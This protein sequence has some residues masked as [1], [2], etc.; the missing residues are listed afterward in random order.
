M[1][2]PLELPTRGRDMG[3]RV[4]ERLAADL[5]SG[6]Y[7]PG[8]LL[9]KE[10]ELCA[11]FGMSRPSVRS[12]LQVLVSLGIVRR[13]SGHGTVVEDFRDWNILDPL[14]TRW[15][16]EHTAPNPQFVA[17]VFE[18][19]H[20]TEPYISALAA[21]KAT[22][23]D[24]LAMEEAFHGMERTLR[25]DRI[26]VVDAAG[27][28]FTDHDVEFHAAIYRATRNLVWAQVAHLLR[29]AITLVVR[30]SNETA[31]ELQDSLQRHRHLMEC[32][33]LRR[34]E[35]AFEAARNVM[36]RTAFDLGLEDV[37]AADDPLLGLWK[38]ALFSAGPSPAGL[39]AGF[40]NDSENDS[41]K[42]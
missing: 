13:I 4:A 42:D 5:F 34:P 9:P 12:G 3:A 6:R 18:F 10:T 16:T 26:R 40:G 36:A 30:A 35:E 8:D 39:P 25:T 31:E 27:K 11:T 24:L 2:E 33:R 32:I 15:M 20:A 38:R 21:R 23:R 41:D 17:A 19:R 1:A 29:P 28:T 22:A 7:Q 14:V 37:G